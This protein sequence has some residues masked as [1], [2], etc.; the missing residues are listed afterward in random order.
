[1]KI[2][3]VL[4]CSGK[5]SRMGSENKLIMEVGGIPMYKHAVK[6]ADELP[7][8]KRV[9]VT[10]YEEISPEGHE[11]I[12]NTAPEKGLS[13][14]VMLGTLACRECDGIIYFVCDQPGLKSETVRRM[15]EAFLRTNKIIVPYAQGKRGNPCIFP[16]RY[17]DELAKLCG[18]K[19]GRRV[20]EKHMD[21]VEY[22][23]ADEYELFDIDTAED[24]NEAEKIIHDNSL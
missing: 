14:S 20:I 8:F 13:L 2:G 12:Y 24:I 23:S 5:S 21:D 7:F 4:L 10:G 9:T 18:D 19:G 6:I 16:K 1:M 17:F 15:I 11:I 3:A 22:V